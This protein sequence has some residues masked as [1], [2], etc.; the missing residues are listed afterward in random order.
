MKA[1]DINAKFLE[2]T[3]LVSLRAVRQMVETAV[4]QAFSCP[5]FWAEQLHFFHAAVEP[6]ADKLQVVFTAADIPDADGFLSPK[7]TDDQIKAL[8]LPVLTEIVVDQAR[9]LV[10]RE[11]W[12]R[13]VHVVSVNR[14]PA[15]SFAAEKYKRWLA[16]LPQ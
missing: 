6:S 4:L 7:L 2:I 8:L 13:H 9:L 16:H 10:E 12:F 3:A 15:S 11:I 1:P 5:N 14:N